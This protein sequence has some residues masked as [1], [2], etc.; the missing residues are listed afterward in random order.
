MLFCQLR[1]T[2]T[3]RFSAKKGK[4]G[5]ENDQVLATLQIGLD[6][7]K[8]VQPHPSLSER[9]KSVRNWSNWYPKMFALSES[10]DQWE[11]AM[12]AANAQHHW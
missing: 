8:L 7:P 10:S 5:A 12:G 2:K 6:L 11:K 3:K 4:N 9:V 1:V